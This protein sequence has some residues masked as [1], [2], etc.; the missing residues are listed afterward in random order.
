MPVREIPNIEAMLDELEY[1]RDVEDFLFRVGLQLPDYA[2]TPLL[3]PANMRS[4]VQRFHYPVDVKMNLFYAAL[5]GASSVQALFAELA[6]MKDEDGLTF[7]D[8]L[9]VT[10]EHIPE[11]FQADSTI[12]KL[13]HDYDRLTK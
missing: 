6:S 11:S 8:H 3:L 7:R 4:C 1:A 9:V 5:R 10:L 12:N 13:L 2:M